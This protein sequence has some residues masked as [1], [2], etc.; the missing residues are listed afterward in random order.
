MK[1]KTHEPYGKLFTNTVIETILHTFS[2]YIMMILGA[3]LIITVK[4][5]LLIITIAWMIVL[6]SILIYF[7][8]KER[9]EK[10]FY[11]LIKY[12]IPKNLKNH[13]TR[14]VDS[15][16]A[17]FPRIK[18]LILPTVLG[19]LTWIIIFSQEYLFVIALGLD[20]P[21]LY[22]LLLFPIANTVGFIPIT[23]AG[24][25]TR[26]I[27]SI[28]LFTTLFNV[29]PEDILVVSLAGFIMTDLFTG[30]IGFLLSLT[31]AGRKD[32]LSQVKKQI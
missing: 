19:S 5:E 25:G 4:P 14:F 27:T 31:E 7:V 28:F 26:E 15:F 32:V 24:L 22:F 20:I 3:L 9:G 16:Y 13:F 30:F 2:L 18:K 1:E 21:Y 29:L 10:L 23:V 8:K 17:D 12:L 6:I 11:T